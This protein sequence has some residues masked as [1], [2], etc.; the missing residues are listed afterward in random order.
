MMIKTTPPLFLFILLLN[1]ILAIAGEWDGLNIKISEA[2][3]AGE[4]DRAAVLAEQVIKIANKTLGRKHPDTLISMNNL[5]ALYKDQ[6]LYEG[7]FFSYG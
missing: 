7:E 1:P 5:V 6:G 4:N 3:N 2:Y